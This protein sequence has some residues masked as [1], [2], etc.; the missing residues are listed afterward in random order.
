MY[1]EFSVWKGPLTKTRGHREL[2]EIEEHSCQVLARG[3]QGEF[4][5]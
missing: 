1:G 5:R 2:S 4:Q 3:K